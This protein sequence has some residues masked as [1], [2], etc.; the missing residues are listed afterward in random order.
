LVLFEIKEKNSKKTLIMLTTFKEF[1]L[2]KAWGREGPIACL[3]TMAITPKHTHTHT[4]THTLSL[5]LSLSSCY[6]VIQKESAHWS[7]H[8]ATT[9]WVEH[10][11]LRVGFFSPLFQSCQCLFW[12]VHCNIMDSLPFHRL[13]PRLIHKSNSQLTC[14]WFFSLPHGKKQRK[15]WL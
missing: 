14:A 10:R 2:Y 4:H 15:R 7:F 3:L 5:S 8:M 6:S 1:V 13:N 9:T 11:L 12:M